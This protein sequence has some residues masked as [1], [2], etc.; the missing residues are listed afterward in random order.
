[1]FFGDRGLEIAR[2]L[3]RPPD[4]RSLRTLVAAAQQEDECLT[5]LYEV[6][7]IARTEVDPQLRDSLATGFTSPI[8]PEETR[9]IRWAIFAAA[10][11]SRSDFSHLVNTSV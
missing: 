5:P 7:A 3:F 11:A 6:D 9:N 1:V 4:V 8:R 2:Q 10:L